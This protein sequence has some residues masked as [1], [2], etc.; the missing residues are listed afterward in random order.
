MLTDLLVQ[1][2]QSIL[3]G[4]HRFDTVMHACL[5]AMHTGRNRQGKSRAG[6]DRQGLGQE[7]GK[8]SAGRHRQGKASTS[9]NRQGLEKVR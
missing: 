7:Q 9:R 4:M 2:E 3:S 6:R 5:Y 1:I 8:A